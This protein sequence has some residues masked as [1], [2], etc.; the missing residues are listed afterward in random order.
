MRAALA[1]GQ[2]QRGGT[3]VEFA[4][5]S[6]VFFSLLIGC[7][8]L[9]RVL[10]YWNSAAEATRLGARMAVVCDKNAAAIKQRM[11]EMLNLV[12]ES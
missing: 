10:F 6:V 2:R 11:R 9:G 12:P 4:I 7:M 5:V 3:A 1:C 8:E